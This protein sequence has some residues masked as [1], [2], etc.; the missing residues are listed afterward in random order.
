MSVRG[1]KIEHRMP[2]A[3]TLRHMDSIA[4]RFRQQEFSSSFDI[5]ACCLIF[6]SLGEHSRTS[7]SLGL[8]LKRKNE[9]QESKKKRTKQRRGTY[10]NQ[11]GY[12]CINVLL[13]DTYV[14]L[15]TYGNK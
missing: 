2:S 11:C 8:A 13:R 5:F 1:A 15:E 3:A 10:R 6:I 14:P 9:E 12:L 7:M 4:Y